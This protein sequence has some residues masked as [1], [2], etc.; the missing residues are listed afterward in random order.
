MP[1]PLRFKV[2]H[3]KTGKWFKEW[4]IASG[5]SDASHTYENGTPRSCP[6]PKVK[7]MPCLNEQGNLYLVDFEGFY[8]SGEFLSPKEWEL[9]IA[10]SKN[11]KGEWH[12]QQVGF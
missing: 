12:Y 4:A 2:K 11:E 8:L 3:K 7:M 6:A 5:K 1:Y 10:T 9:W